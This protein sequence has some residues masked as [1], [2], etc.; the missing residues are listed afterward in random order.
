MA[1]ILASAA[2]GFLG[3]LVW[4]DSIRSN[5]NYMCMRGL[6]AAYIRGHM[7]YAKIYPPEVE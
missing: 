1:A 7:F 5:N 3:F 4:T 6:V 2:S